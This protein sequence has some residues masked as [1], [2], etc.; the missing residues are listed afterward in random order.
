MFPKNQSSSQTLLP[1][2]YPFSSLPIISH[3]FFP[4]SLNYFGLSERTSRRVRWTIQKSRRK[5]NECQYKTTFFFIIFFKRGIFKLS[6]EK[7][8]QKDGICRILKKKLYIYTRKS[9]RKNSMHQ[10]LIG[11]FEEWTVKKKSLKVQNKTD[12]KPK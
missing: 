6:W 5:I 10:Y 8:R 4:M 2:L 1:F 3:L 11:L 9:S 7:I 12:M